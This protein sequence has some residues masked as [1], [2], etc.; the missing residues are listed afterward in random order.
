MNEP[1]QELQEQLEVRIVAMLLGEAS[2]FETAQL[3]EI[4]AKYPELAAFH[5]RMKGTIGLAQEVSRKTTVEIGA[6][7]AKAW[8]PTEQQP[9]LSAERRQVLMSCFR[10]GKEEVISLPEPKRR[11]M[12]WLAPLAAA[13]VVVL[14]GMLFIPTLKRL[15][16]ET[17]INLAYAPKEEPALTP[18]QVLS[19]EKH[20]SESY[21]KSVNIQPVFPEPVPSPDA[22]K[23][24]LASNSPHGGVFLPQGGIVDANVEYGINEQKSQ[25]DGDDWFVKLQTLENKVGSGRAQVDAQQTPEDLERSAAIWSLTKRQLAAGEWQRADNKQAVGDS[26][27]FRKYYDLNASGEYDRNTRYRNLSANDATSGL[28]SNEAVEFNAA[29]A[30]SVTNSTAFT[31]NLPSSSPVPAHSPSNRFVTRSAFITGSE[32]LNIDQVHQWALKSQP[33]STLGDERDEAAQSAKETGDRRRGG[34]VDN[35][36]TIPTRALRATTAEK[37]A[38]EIS[39]LSEVKAKVGGGSSAPAFSGGDKNGIRLPEVQTATGPLVQD[40][41]LLFEMGRLDEAE[42][43]LKDALRED[44]DRKDASYYLDL[45]KEQRYAKEVAQKKSGSR[46]ALVEVEKAWNPPTKRETAVP[47]QVAA[48]GKAVGR[49]SAVSDELTKKP[50][51][52]LASIVNHAASASAPGNAPQT[53]DAP[54][55]KPITPPPT[56]QPEINTRQNA[57]STFSLNVSDVSFKLAAASLQNGAMP[58][59]GSIRVE[60]FINAFNY[61]DPAPTPGAPLAFA[62][63]RA[64]YPFAHNRD[65]VRFSVQTAARGRDA[66]KPL[67]LVILLDN[68][69]SMERLDR[70][71][72]V[73]E[74]L[75]VLAQQLGP[76]DRISVIT[77][78]RTARLWVDG[79]AGGDAQT[80]LSQ[81]LN[82]NPEG[83]TN[84]EGAL[85][86]AYTTAVKHFMPTGV[87]R[88]ILLTDGAANLGNVEPEELKQKVVAHRQ[89]GVALDCFG[90]GWEGYNDDLLEV[91]SR[92]GDGRYGFLNQLEQAAPEFA[93]Q[94]AGALNVAA[95]DVKTQVEFNPN[96][97]TSWRQIG[98]AR[99]Q[100]TKE[101][102]R[103]N[104][105]DAAEIAAAEQGNALYVI[106]TNPQ[107]SGPIGVVRVRFKVPATGEYVEK[108]WALPYEPRVPAVDQSSPALRLAVTASGFGEWLS[109]SP[110]AAEVTLPALQG[111]ITGVPE[112]FSPDPRPQQL[113]MMIDQARRIEG[114]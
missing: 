83:G 4:L 44:P 105:V 15:R 78:S 96:R 73:R 8:T 60:E 23:K 13:A 1:N 12:S 65:V 59:A 103:D 52:R 100:L 79:M 111:L 27:D 55:R 84:L 41:K 19:S 48:T 85:D 93:N 3:Q 64:R 25:S 36:S 5:E 112:T 92:N 101:Q 90:I 51:E 32:V 9:K 40:G 114:K 53:E 99:H 35:S 89:K 70:V 67:N 62:W 82:L 21:S 113:R 91:L 50:Q 54:A 24:P 107:G 109:T 97:V 69:G 17:K 20:A 68:S 87:N 6:G 77:F 2:A 102:F 42:K 45:V 66:Q 56:P 33:K 110:F 106:E 39:K 7:Q 37:S 71:A 63:E 75:K 49:S 58:D 80:F 34:E 81:V 47:S 108:E 38:E 94:L 31:F 28:K 76:Q 10:Q 95:S 61:R 72:I 29:P 43:K 11:R 46:D 104:T 30:L 18:E 74:A 86:L 57:F 98:Y 14:M 88:V 22:D 16:P 26:V